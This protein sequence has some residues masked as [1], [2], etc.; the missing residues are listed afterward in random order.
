MA[1]EATQA[2]GP[3]GPETF[4]AFLDN[5]APA[6]P[7]KAKPE[8][9]EQV[10]EGEVTDES[11]GVDAAET[12]ST[13]EQPGPDNDAPLELPETLE[14]LAEAL[15]LTA[16]DL[17]GKIK[18]TIQVDGESKQV[19]LKDA[20]AGHRR[21][22][23]YTRK[24]QEVAEQRKA[25]DS[26]RAAM[27]NERRQSASFLANLYKSLQESVVGSM[28]DQSLLDE[29]SQNYNPAKYMRDERAYRESVR[30]FR[31]AESKLN[32]A[33]SYDDGQARARTQ[34][35]VQKE[36]DL[37]KAK[38]T[39]F[40]DPAK[41]KVAMEAI[42]T[43]GLSEGFTPQELAGFTDHRL[44]VVLHKAA[45]WDESQK[46]GAV[47]AKKVTALPKFQKP[48]AKGPEKGEKPNSAALVKRLARNPS[49][50]KAVMGL[51]GQFA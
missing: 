6:K 32:Q 39:D 30:K 13:D 38:I 20:L 47:A 44:A 8:A 45:K 50:K 19:P 4:Q 17:L 31:E 21:E 14:G 3:V 12:Q 34:Q 46:K 37:L 36:R 28:P 25:I 51:F 11:E 49:D 33:Q 35:S 22:A 2:P 15:G 29:T 48:G 43:Y 9:T 26:E 10:A 24:T 5:E 18:A 1:D 23:D 41:A 16:D 7:E 40:S 42:K 27:E